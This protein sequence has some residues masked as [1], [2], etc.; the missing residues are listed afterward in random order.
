MRSREVK[1]FISFASDA[2]EECKLIKDIVEEETE[3]HFLENGYK[4]TPVCWKD[5]P[6][7]LGHPQKE[8][9]D[10]VIIGQ[11]CRL[12]IIV[13]KNSLGTKYENGET[14]IEHEYELAKKFEKEILVYDCDFIIDKRRSEVDIEQ[15]KM[16][17]DFIQRVSCEGLIRKIDSIDNF[18]RIFRRDFVQWAKKLITY[19]SDLSKTDISPEKSE[20]YS[21]GF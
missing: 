21:G 13:L 19:E 7:G 6:P 3:N 20:G 1:I 11:D 10:P 15:L 2:E 5:I 9:I 4:F 18:Q 14:G 17:N 12:V 8:K 16:V